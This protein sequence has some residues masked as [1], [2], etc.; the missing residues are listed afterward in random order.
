[1]SDAVTL[2]VEPRTKTGSKVSRALRKSDKIPAILYSH[3]E[4]AELITLNPK[5]VLHAIRLGKSVVSIHQGKK[6]EQAIIREVQWDHLGRDILHVD[7]GRVSADE[8][9]KVHVPVVTKGMAPGVN[10][11]G[12]LD[13]TMHSVDIECLVT[14]VPQNISVN[15]SELKIG[16]SVHVRELQ[17]P[18]GVRVLNDQDLVVLHVVAKRE[19]EIKPTEGTSPEP[20][21]L[22]KK[23]PEEG[24]E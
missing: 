20:E 5:E 9:I 4:A 13:I 1:M 17:L 11:G 3:G 16:D 14:Q 21:V 7:L 22:T 18:P 19:E 12:V 10:A 24:K 8:K 6:T 23:K 15:I 2:S